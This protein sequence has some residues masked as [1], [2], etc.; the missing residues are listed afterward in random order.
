[1][2]NVYVVGIALEN[3]YLNGNGVNQPLGIFTPH[4]NG[5]P[6]SR[7]VN[8]GHATQITAL[9]ALIDCLHSLKAQ[10]W[11]RVQV[12]HPPEH[13]QGSAGRCK[14]SDG[15]FLW[16]PGLNGGQPQMLLGQPIIMSEYAPSSITTDSLRAGVGRLLLVLDR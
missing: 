6:T 10:Y 13:P 7:D 3:A 1:M 16:G 4:A 14:G 9:R 15:Q 8:S 12:V 11:P 2:R 5:I